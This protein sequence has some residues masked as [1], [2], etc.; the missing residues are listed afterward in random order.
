MTRE[1][2]ERY[3]RYRSA[4]L[5]WDPV[6][7]GRRPLICWV[8]SSFSFLGEDLDGSGFVEVSGRM[9]GG[10][11]Y[12]PDAIDFFGPWEDEGRELKV[13]DRILQRARLF[14]FSNWPVLWAMTEVFVAERTSTTCHIGYV[15][16]RR[17]FG[18][19]LWQARLSRTEEG[20]ELEV[21]SISGPQSWLF[22][23][24]LPLGR[25]LQQRAWRRAIL[26]FARIVEGSSVQVVQG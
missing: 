13:G 20:L 21:E 24:G 25:Y 5:T 26:E 7:G 10:R 14:P 18:R 15:T 19:G 16:T 11:Y 12:P 2:R 6:K 9:L 4:D 1:I 8:D 23:V 22:W 17:H 3:E